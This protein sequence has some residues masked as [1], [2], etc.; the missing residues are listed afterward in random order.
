MRHLKIAGFVVGALAV[1]IFTAV[2]LALSSGVQT[3]AVRRAVARQ[4]GMAVEIGRVEAGFSEARIS[5]LRVVRDGLVISAGTI[6]TRYSA[7]AYLLG[8]RVDIDELIAGDLVV[9]LQP[10]PEASEAVRESAGAAERPSDSGPATAAAR[11]PARISQSAARESFEGLLAG[12]RLPLEVRVGRV[13]I[14]GKISM[15][16]LRRGN[17]SVRATD[18]GSGRSG[19]VEWT[20]DF[21]DTRPGA[22]L[23]SLQSTGALQVQIDADR[24]IVR[25]ELDATA[26]ATGP[27][28]PK[29]QVRLQAQAARPDSGGG[30]SYSSTISLVR[31]GVTETVLSANAD[32]AAARGEIV[33]NWNIGLRNGQLGPVLASL[34]L[35][36]AAITSSGTFR[37]EPRLHAAAVSGRIQAVVSRLENLVPALAALPE[38][39]VVSAFDGSLEGTNVELNALDLEMSGEG[40]TFAQLNL[41]QKVGF[42]PDD[43][44]VTLADSKAAAARISFSE[45]PIAWAQPFVTAL[46]L[47]RGTLSLGLAVEGEPDGSRIH[48]RA[49]EPLALRGVTI[50]YTDGVALVEEAALSLNPAIDYSPAGVSARLAALQLAVAGG[51]TLGGSVSAEVTQLATTPV[52]VFKAALQVRFATLLR[53]FLK[54]D[55]G[56][57]ATALEIDGRHEGTTI[58]LTRISATVSREAGG[59]VAA[60]DAAQAIRADLRAGTVDAANP[61]AITARVRIGEIPLVWAEPYVA[62]SKISGTL[63]GGALELT[64]RNAGDASF[65]TTAPIAVRGLNAAIDGQPRVEG[66]DLSLDLAAG[67]QGDRFDYE[68][69]R[70]EIR[71]GSALLA[72]LGVSG[73]VTPGPKPDAKARGNFEADA[74]KLLAQPALAGFATLARGRVVGTFEGS[75]GDGVRVKAVASAKDLVAREENRAL[76]DAEISL[77]ATLNPDGSGNITL[78]LTVSH[79][80]RKSDV[81]LDGTFGRAGQTAAWV[82]AGKISGANLVVD[83][84]QALAALVPAAPV[85]PGTPARKPA[86]RDAAPFWKGVNGRAELDVKRVLYGKDAA[87]G[88]VRGTVSLTDSRLALDSLAGSF[89]DKPFTIGATLTFVDAQPR[90]YQLSGLVDV[91]GV[92]VG[93]LLR[94]ANPKEKPMIEST[95]KVT[96][97]LSGNGGTL[98]DLLARVYGNFEVVGGKG[99]LR[100]LGRKGETVGAASTVLGLAGALAGS[101]NT[102]ALGRLGH[103]LEE[104]QFE[105]FALKVE[106]DATLNMKFTTVEFLS[107][108]KRLTGTGSV[109]YVEGATFDSWPFQFELRLA[110]KDFMAQLLNEARV[111]SG[112]QDDKGYYPMAVTFPVSGTA[113]R[114]SNGLWRILAG[115]AAR[116]G[117]EG[118]LRR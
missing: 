108:S 87:I 37:F 115:S 34:K 105:T 14:E 5:N 21:T 96:A 32:F 77:T 54:F 86:D 15:P 81:A 92:D 10:V 106:R 11:M 16:D 29:D 17:F 103:E 90:P 36:E 33:G 67:K 109:K 44:R 66:L 39:R 111:L 42:R 27:N 52:A 20:V 91:S 113:G 71:Q 12:A 98:E 94:A 83:D 58:E 62:N 75:V 4:P 100:A 80:G 45:V 9:E 60:V 70:L 51:D 38:V 107:P 110:G 116:A 97:N 25:A 65:T 63:A 72:N 18:L 89:R 3:W 114:V 55:P 59:L 49:L 46:R 73:D 35:P 64:F 26:A 19:R 22:E 31:N 30:E 84:L 68:L 48:L 95:V 117:I 53:P 23:H 93:E 99:V 8:G 61:G 74:A 102:M 28:L 41:L 1:I 79:A 13:S 104:M 47:E 78:P 82:F 56:P 6:G 50:R 24:R 76:G 43:R 112:E 85:E 40:R 69:R 2:A 118:L 7:W 88:G 57:L 101:S